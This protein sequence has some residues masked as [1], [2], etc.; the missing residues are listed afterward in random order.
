MTIGD[1]FF[2][3]QRGNADACYMNMVNIG[4]FL[5]PIIAGYIAEA[6]GWRF[7]YWLCTLFYGV[8][9][10]AFI[11]LF[12]E[13]KYT[14][15]LQAQVGQ[16]D[17]SAVDEEQATKKDKDIDAQKDS[18]EINKDR[19]P[20][21]QVQIDAIETGEVPIDDTIPKKTYWQRMAFIT[22]TDEPMW[23]LYW[24]PFYLLLCFPNVLY[25]GLTYAFSLCWITVLANIQAIYMPLPPYNMGPGAVGL[26]SLGPFIGAVLGSF[27]SGFFS[28]WIVVYLAKRNHGYYEPEMR[29]HASHLGAVAQPAGL[30]MFGICLARQEHWMLL[31]VGGA[32]FGFGLGCVSNVSI[33]LVIDSYRAVSGEA[34]VGIAFLR[35]CFSIA[36]VF[37][38]DPWLAAQ[39]LQ[40][41]FIVIGVWAFVVCMLHVP[42]LVWGRKF[43]SMTARRYYVFL[44]SKGQQDRG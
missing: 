35:N 6:Q 31:Q 5:A 38:I 2:I 14:P 39:G 18:E 23:P 16:L 27:Y 15:T 20:L 17:P 9:L 44:E 30:L 37:A 22:K 12:E 41:M 36:L 25:C 13:T 34:F 21:T 32:I 42:L 11:F 1:L 4:S 40:N 19:R 26:Q 10:L 29:L 3:H 43:R 24:R 28:D 8:I 33:T 7:T